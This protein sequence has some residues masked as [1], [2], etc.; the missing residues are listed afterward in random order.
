MIYLVKIVQSNRFEQDVAR[1]RKI[2]P[3]SKQLRKLSP[4]LNEMGVLRV[5]GRLAHSKLS[6]QQKHPILLPRSHRL[7]FLIIEE[8]HCKYFHPGLQTLQFLLLQQFWI[9]SPKRAIR[10]TLSNCYKCFRAQPKS[11][12]PFMGNLPVDRISHIK[13][14]RCVGVDFCGPFLVTLGKR[15]S[16]KSQKACIC[17]FICFPTKAIHLELVS[18]LSAEAFLA[19]LR[20]FIA[21]K[22]RC[23]SIHS[24]CGTNFVGVNKM[25]ADMMKNAAASDTIEW[26]F[27]PPFAPHF[28]GLWEAGIKSVKTHLYRVIGSQIPTFEEMYTV[29]TQIESLLNSRPLCVISSDPN[30][31]TALTL[32]HF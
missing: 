27:N 15:R 8:F 21:L 24:D 29:L 22:G 20:R 4:F 6:F 25:L 10:E 28:G 31:L 9:L 12:E 2:L 26:K 17:L 32:G 13:A 18:E 3:I 23:V 19:A 7:T 30:D 16:I 5:G 1:I 14:F 11:V